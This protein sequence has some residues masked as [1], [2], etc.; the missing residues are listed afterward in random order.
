MGLDTSHECWHGAYSA[1]YRFRHELA[2]A[3]GYP[4][5]EERGLEVMDLPWD[6]YTEDNLMGDWNDEVPEDPLLV[7]LVH[8]DCDGVIH[9][10]QG[11]PLADR[12][13]ELIPKL[14]AGVGGG[15]IG[16]WRDTVQQFVDGLRS[17]A[18]HGDDVEF[19]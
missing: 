15:H 18:L 6:L 19:A 17:A 7:L 8:S 13:E 9:P 5:A 3:A 2:K 4:I 10:K 14:P 11:A 16:D 1:F 12:M